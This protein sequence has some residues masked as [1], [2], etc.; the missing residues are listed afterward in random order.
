M[1]KGLRGFVDDALSR[2]GPLAVEKSGD[3]PTVRPFDYKLHRALFALYKIL[4]GQNQPHHRSVDRNWPAGMGSRLGLG[5]P[6]GLVEIGRMPLLAH[7]LDQ[8][9]DIEDVRIVTG[10]LHERRSSGIS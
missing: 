6:M 4:E 2:T 5:I 7:L 1:R 3:F 10:W 9:T 8:M